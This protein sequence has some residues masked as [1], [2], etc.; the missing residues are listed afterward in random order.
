[1]P[2]DLRDL[3][4]PESTSGISARAFAGVLDDGNHVAPG[5]I[6]QLSSFGAVSAAK[7]RPF[8]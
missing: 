4:T 3:A 6:A 7:A 2:R 1:M 5:S 8:A